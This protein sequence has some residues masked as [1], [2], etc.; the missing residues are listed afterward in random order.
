M[1]LQAFGEQFGTHLAYNPGNSMLVGTLKTFHNMKQ[2]K[3]IH[4]NTVVNVC[5]CKDL[6]PN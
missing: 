4:G 5:Q 6:E 3:M 1:R 2:G